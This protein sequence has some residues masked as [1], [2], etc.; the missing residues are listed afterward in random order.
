MVE[1]MDRGLSLFRRDSAELV[2]RFSLRHALPLDVLVDDAIA[3]IRR[4]ASP[5][6]GVPKTTIA[7]L[8]AAETARTWIPKGAVARWSDVL[9]NILRNAVQSTEEMAIAEARNRGETVSVTLSPWVR[10]EMNAGTRIEIRD[11]GLGMSPE[12]SARIWRGDW[13]RH[14]R[15]RGNGLNESKLAFLKEHA[16]LRVDTKP[17][18]G[19]TFFVDIPSPTIE[20]RSPS[21]WALRP[22]QGLALVLLLLVVGLGPFV[23][24]HRSIV[25]LEK[26]GDTVVSALDDRGGVAWRRNL[27]E[28]VLENR[29]RGGGN[30]GHDRRAVQVDRRGEAKEFLVSTKADRGPGSLV[31]LDSLG[32]ILWRRVL[33]WQNP[34][35]VKLGQLESWWQARIEWGSGRGAAYVVEVRDCVYA[36]TSIQFLTSQNELIGSYLHPGHLKFHSCQDLDGDGSNE[37]ILYGINNAAR[38]SSRLESCDPSSGTYFGCVVLLDADHLNGQAFPWST[39]REVP[40]ARETAYLLIPALDCGVSAEVLFVDVGRPDPGADLIIEVR[41]A[42]GRVWRV[43]SGLRPL[44]CFAGDGSTASRLGQDGKADYLHPLWFRDGVTLSGSMPPRLNGSGGGA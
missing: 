36:P 4:E 35:D 22:L 11:R 25:S 29:P 31:L 23:P 14:G 21:S 15:G 20:I 13:G 16:R 38:R 9:R 8:T 37:L 28:T 40:R 24:P 5:I 3:A 39:W 2:D 12:E 42:D 33:S 30:R 1:D 19:T 32:D 44:D 10:E 26:T 27:H 18:A 41:V 43:D 7:R 17:G 34:R 6:P